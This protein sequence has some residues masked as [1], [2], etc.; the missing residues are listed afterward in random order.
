MKL[1]LNS[2]TPKSDPNPIKINTSNG[3]RH[4]TQ[5]SKIQTNN[6]SMTLPQSND[7]QTL[8]NILHNKMTYLKI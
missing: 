8:N 4:T 6:T 7:K 1:K 3:K 2:L 5:N